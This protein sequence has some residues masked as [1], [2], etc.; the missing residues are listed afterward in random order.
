M[1]K[2][3]SK[4]IIII[5]ALVLVAIWAEIAKSPSD[6]NV[7]LYFFNVG[8][9]DAELIQKG[10]YQILIDGGPDDAVLT[11]IGQVMPLHDRKIEKLIL[12]HPHADHITGLNQILQRYEIGSIYLSGVLSSSNLYLEFLDKIKQKN[13]ETSVPEI[14]QTVDTFPDAKLSFLWPGKRYQQQSIDNLNNSSLVTKFC[15]FEQC[16]LYLGDLETDGQEEMFAN[17]TEA[18]Y[19]AQIIKIAHHG[20]RNGTDQNLLDRIK[21]QYAVIEVGADNQYGH[22]HAATLD[23]LQ[24]AGIRIFRTDRDGMVEFILSSNSLTL[25]K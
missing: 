16:V 9:G 3:L 10:D 25:T 15:Y 21:P 20:S 19:Q 17:N 13:V 22:P 11:Q 23:L 14:N 18:N 2:K 5:L 24:K 1:A 6:G 8:Q 12:T 7:H 4:I